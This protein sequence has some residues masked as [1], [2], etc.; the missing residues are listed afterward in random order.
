VVETTSAVPHGGA[1]IEL[2]HAETGA[3]QPPG[4]QLTV[5]KA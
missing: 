4:A 1:W 5:K 3:L 2:G